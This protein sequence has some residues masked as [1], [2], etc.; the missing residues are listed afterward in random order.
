MLSASFLSCTAVEGRGVSG[1]P[2]VGTL[3][4]LVRLCPSV[5]FLTLFPTKEEKS[6][7]LKERLDQIY[8][9]NERRCSRAPVYGRDLLRICSVVGREQTPWPA[10]SDGSQRKG[11][12]PAGGYMPPSHGQ[13]DLILTLTQRQACLQDVI[14]R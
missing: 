13:K 8:F 1:S 14:D 9:V 10:A 3:W 2:C 12:G 5:T 6:R 7:L 11:A 4:G